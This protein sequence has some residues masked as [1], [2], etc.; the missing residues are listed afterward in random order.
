MKINR[1]GTKDPDYEGVITA[2]RPNVMPEILTHNIMKLRA[3]VS[4]YDWNI[5]KIVQKM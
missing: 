4:L 3:V 2:S 1:R 5:K